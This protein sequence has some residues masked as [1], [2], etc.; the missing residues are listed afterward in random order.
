MRKPSPSHD[1]PGDGASQTPLLP[2]HTSNMSSIMIRWALQWR[3][4]LLTV[5]HLFMFTA[6][7]FLAF[8]LR[9]DFNIPPEELA[10][11]WRT[12]PWYLALKLVVFYGAKNF[13]GWW[14]YVSFSDL[15]AL[16]RA[17][18]IS[19][20]LIVSVDYFLINEYQ[21]PRGIVLLD[22]AATL[23]VVG[24]MRCSWRMVR[25]Q[26]WPFF[27]GGEFRRALLIGGDRHSD[28]LAR[29][30]HSCQELKYRV[31]GFLHNERLH[32]GLR[33]GN[34]PIVGFPDDAAALARQYGA[35]EV[36]VISDALD[37][38]RLRAIIEDCE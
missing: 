4:A 32:H 38:K 22:W 14:R 13:H 31:V 16:V 15:A 37:G 3:L 21:I 34:M 9:F 25:E 28:A 30:I 26:L 24:G 8:E 18:S 35:E 10:L 29:H 1:D 19:T 33:L 36:L 20:L 7:Y 17:A 5:A 11:L 23:L 12:L 6:C 27:N 2:N